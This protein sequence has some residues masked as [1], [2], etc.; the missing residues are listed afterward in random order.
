MRFVNHLHRTPFQLSTSKIATGLIGL[1]L[2]AVALPLFAQSGRY[3]TRLYP[4]GRDGRSAAQV[5]GEGEVSAVL[6]GNQLSISGNFHGLASNA[7]EAKLMESEVAGARGR[8]VAN[9]NIVEE[10]DGRVWG[11]VTLTQAQTVALRD[12][13]LYVQINSQ[14]APEANLWGWLHE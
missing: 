1:L 11:T 14:S 13:K 10:N 7:T 3:R 12:F 8:E 4:V 2:I 5:Q 9:L 6:I